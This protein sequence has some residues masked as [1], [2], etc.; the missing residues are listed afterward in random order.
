MSIWTNNFRII[1]LKRKLSF[2][3]GA[4]YAA[5]IQI[6]W[7]IDLLNYIY[8]I[9]TA[10]IRNIQTEYIMFVEISPQSG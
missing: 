3:L 7:H 6:N 1:V 2:K 10:C 9:Y 5:V 8:S 4:A